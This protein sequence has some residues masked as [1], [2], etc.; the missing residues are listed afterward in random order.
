MQT[1]SQFSPLENDTALYNLKSSAKDRIRALFDSPSFFSVSLYQAAR[2]IPALLIGCEQLCLCLLPAVYPVAG[3]GAGEDC[4]VVGWGSPVE[5]EPGA[6]TLLHYLLSSYY[7]PGQGD[8]RNRLLDKLCVWLTLLLPH[9]HDTAEKAVGFVST[10]GCAH[11]QQGPWPITF[12]SVIYFISSILV[13][14]YA[15]ILSLFCI[16]L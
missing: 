13:N 11:F 7:K 1:L 12:R 9:S 3:C 2:W 16:S 5:Y 8:P 10:L 15:P 14:A 6:G 4:C